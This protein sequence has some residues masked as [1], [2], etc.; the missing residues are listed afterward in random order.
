[1]Q[2]MTQIYSPNLIDL[3]LPQQIPDI[4]NKRSSSYFIE[5][6]E[7]KFY[8]GV[9]IENVKINAKDRT[10]ML[11]A[12]DMR[13]S[14]RNVIDIQVD[15]GTDDELAEAQDEFNQIYDKYVEQYGHICDDSNLKKIFSRDSAY[16]LLRSLEEYGKEGYKGKSPIFSK[17]MI[18]PHRP[19]INADTPADA[20]AISMQEVGRVDLGYMAALTDQTKE[21][22]I[23]ALEFERIYFD[24][25]KQEYQIAEEFL[26][27][28]IRAKME[29]TENKIKQVDNEINKKLVSSV[30]Q[31]DN[32]KR[33]EPKN[34]IERKILECNPEGDYHFS[35]SSYYD[36]DEKVYYDDYIESQKDNREFLAEIA[37][38][39]GIS[40]DRDKVGE[41]L[42]DKPLIALEAIRR[43]RD[44][45][46]VKQADLLILSYL[47]TI[48]ED[49]YRDNEEHDL[50]LYDFLKKKLAKFE[51]DFNAIK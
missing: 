37:L 38:I 26:S 27:G 23:N 8:N 22:L 21:E 20:L 41:I 47:R 33:Y 25:Q 3:P 44:V 24:S 31:I 6:G 30:L 50:M 40:V 43:G 1:M 35:F 28:D 29:F 14:V 15:D 7:L 32:I 17:R 9:K 12:M 5:N 46:Y 45:G 19:P 10:Q 51:N 48:N 18:E 39:H 42:A 13:D 36:A 49:F 16:P 2:S 4:E 34:E 11:L